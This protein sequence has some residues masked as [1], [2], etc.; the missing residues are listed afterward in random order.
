M[1]ASNTRDCFRV[2]IGKRVVGV[3]FDAL[4]VGRPDLNQGNKSLIFDDGTALTV[5]TNGSFWIDLPSD[6]RQ[7][8]AEL[9]KRLNE[10]KAAISE[11]LATAGALP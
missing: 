4:P 10:A 9:E 7:A 5:N 1:T 11:T 2:C 8:I 6:V 3:L